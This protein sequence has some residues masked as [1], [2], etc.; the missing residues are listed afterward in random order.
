MNQ[1]KMIREHL[2]ELRIELKRAVTAEVRARQDVNSLAKDYITALRR[3]R[4][5]LE[6]VTSGPARGRR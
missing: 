1:L 5:A 4:L 3:Y 6:H 2:S